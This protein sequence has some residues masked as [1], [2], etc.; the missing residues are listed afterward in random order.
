MAK[1]LITALLKQYRLAQKSPAVTSFSNGY[2]SFGDNSGG[3]TSLTQFNRTISKTTDTESTRT[4]M[5]T[6]GRASQGAS[7]FN[8]TD[9]YH[10]KGYIA[11]LS[12]TVN[13]VV[14]ATDSQSSPTI[15][16]TVERRGPMVPCPPYLGRIYYF[17]GYRDTDATYRADT[18]YINS[19]T[20]T[21]TNDT[22]ITAQRHAGVSLFNSS[23]VWLVGGY[24]I[25]GYTTNTIY[26]WVFASSSI[27]TLSE[28]DVSNSVAYSLNSLSAGYRV[29]GDGASYDNN[30]KLTYATDTLSSIQDSPDSETLYNG[31]QYVTLTDGYCWTGWRGSTLYRTLHKLSFATETWTNNSYTTAD[32]NDGWIQST[33]GF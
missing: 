4:D 1:I 27:S 8:S 23:F 13:K 14:G 5:S 26:K 10:I 12:T 21:A 33:S 7:S 19:S 6:A 16:F 2:F 30:K 25:N 31:T 17:G 9:I 22:N 29:A 18:T 28:T 20:D 24:D 11:G 15:A 32:A 3:F